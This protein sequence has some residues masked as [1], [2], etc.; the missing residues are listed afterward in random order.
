MDTCHI[1]DAGYDVS[2]FDALL[3]EFDR[4]IG[5]NR[6]AVIHV[7]DSKNP[8]GSHKDRHENIGQGTIGFDALYKIVHNPR[9]AHVTKILE[10]P[11]ID[12]KPPYKEEIEKLREIV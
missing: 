10:T 3:D 1:H 2:D 5:L 12:G 11:Y 7:N 9:V 4:V 8:R 6:L